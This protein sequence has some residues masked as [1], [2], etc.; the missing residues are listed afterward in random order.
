MSHSFLK[1]DVIGLRHQI[2]FAGN[3]MK[4][5]IPDSYLEEDSVF[6]KVLGNKIETIGM[7]WFEVDGKKYELTLPIKMQFEYSEEERFKGKISPL[8]PSDSYHVF[9]LKKG[10]AFLYDKAHVRQLT[11]L[12]TMLLR[13]I[14]QGKM[15]RTVGYSESILILMKLL[16]ASGVNSGIDVSSA[17]LEIMLSELYRNKHNPS[18]PFRKLITD[19]R[20]HA[21]DYDFRMVRMTKVPQLNS[22]FNSLLGEDTFNQLANC[23]VRNREGLK[24]RPSPM[25]KL[26]KM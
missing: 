21:S 17:V 22:T 24:D 7:F 11:D 9:I 3:Q 18:E 23:V 4:I 16:I 2:T 14:D 5:Y 15:P 10:D 12:E 25:E 19:T 20:T 13:I 8:L 6:A 26:L 1:E